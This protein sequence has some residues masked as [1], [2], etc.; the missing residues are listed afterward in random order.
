[1]GTRENREKKNGFVNGY[2]MTQNLD[3]ESN[4]WGDGENKRRQEAKFKPTVKER[5]EGGVVR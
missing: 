1:M 2:T 5:E 3:E 4:S